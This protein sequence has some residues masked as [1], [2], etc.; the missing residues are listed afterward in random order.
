[1]VRRRFGAD[2]KGVITMPSEIL[3]DITELAS[4][5]LQ[6]RGID[7]ITKVEPVAGGRNNRAY[8][9]TGPACSWLLK[10][11]FRDSQGLRDRCASE[12]E[13]SHFCWQRGVTWGPEPLAHDEKNHAALFE[14]I[15]GRRLQKDEVADNH[16]E[17]A[18]QFVAEVNLHRNHPS[19]TNLS[20]AAEACFSLKEHI[21]CVDR[22]VDRLCSLSMTDE[23]DTQ[24][25]DWLRSSLLPAWEVIVETLRSSVDPEQYEN[26]ILPSDRCLS[27]SDF[28][29]H[30][31][32]ITPTGRLRFFDF[33]Y[34]GWDDPAKLICDFFWQQDLP[35]PRHSM[36]HL[37]EVLSLPHS[38]FELER[39]VKLLFP[40]YAVKWCCLLLNEFVREDRLRREFSQSSPISDTRRTQQLERA[41]HLLRTVQN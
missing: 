29:F 4:H 10:Q 7:L 9:V 30:N 5:L 33:E 34:A 2:C 26:L 11:Y 1:M 24:L 38:K 6:R 17:Q 28:G 22:R 3:T 25:Q 39:R 32:L 37:V 36:N 40:V 23:T 20:D 15:E 27:P 35:A 8:R 21:A 18:A 19:A 31:A 12:W 14:F 13:W 16:V 41:K